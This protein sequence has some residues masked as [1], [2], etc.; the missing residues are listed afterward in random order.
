M[1][2]LWLWA[3]SALLLGGCA[4]WQ[5]NPDV[6]VGGN[7]AK[8]FYLS[9]KV[10]S[11]NYNRIP[12]DAKKFAVGNDF[13]ELDKIDGIK[14][15][16]KTKSLVYNKFTL[17][18][19]RKLFL[20]I[21]A[22]WQFKAFLN[23]KMIFDSSKYGGKPLFYTYQVEASGKAGENL[24][25]IEV[26]RG[27]ATS[28]FF[29]GE[30]VKKTYDFSKPLEVKA[31]ISA[32]SGIIK[33]MNAVNNGPKAAASSQTKSNMTAWQKAKIPYSRNHDASISGY[34][35]AH[36]VDVHQIFPDF[37]KDP[38]DPKSYD[39]TLTDIY[40]KNIL[41]GGTKIFYR[42]G[43]RIEH[44]IVKYGT[45][46]PADFK[47][48]AIICEHIIRHYTEGWANGYKWDIRYWE[49]WNEPDLSSGKANKKTWGGTD[50]E[51]FE[52][53]RLTAFHLK[54][55]FPQL[56][57]GGPALC[58]NLEWARSFL[59]AMTAGERVPIDFFSWHIYTAHPSAVVAT[60]RQDRRLLDEFGYN[61]TESIL[62][63]WNYVRNWTSAF[64]YSIETIIGIKG[65]AFSAAVMNLS[66]NA[67]VDMLMYY[68]ARP[69]TGFNGLFDFYT[70]R[71]L[72]TYHV[73]CVWSELAA[74]GKQFKLDYPENPEISAVGATDGK[75]NAGIL[76]SRYTEEDKLPGPVKIVV[77]PAG[78]SLKGAKLYLL[79]KDNNLAEKKLSFNF[80]GS[81]SFKMEANTVV[82]LKKSAK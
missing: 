63:E 61:N 44:S 53:Y 22:D 27:K 45:K 46:K 3:V 60:A 1:K 67:P 6:F 52:M 36:I 2:K 10:N 68:D 75:G 81:V 58:G 34:G 18:N 73:F 40:H 70:M 41:K 28:L 69:G 16:K 48:W 54:K 30:G 32:V 64:V 37:S 50:E 31:D 21:G 26:V 51:F 38:Y 33:P 25:T 72:K 13:V 49:I 43:S 79:D 66:Q 62:N 76:F 82:Y 17:K 11:A 24:L 74:L 29:C 56:K 71:P 77:K 39:F 7:L 57:I 78:V 23:G 80:D 59:K 15:K 5:D 19:D 35:S 12:A 4:A 65:A 8:E 47:K 20:L 42:L 55:N 9:R 14:R